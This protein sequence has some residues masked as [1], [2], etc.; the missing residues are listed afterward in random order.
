MKKNLH[1]AMVGSVLDGHFPVAGQ[2]N[3]S[4]PPLILKNSN[5]LDLKPSGVQHLLELLAFSGDSEIGH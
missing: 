2:P 5:G 3:C 4:W 1:Y